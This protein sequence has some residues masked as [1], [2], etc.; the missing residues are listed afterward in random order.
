MVTAFEDVAVLYRRFAA[1]EVRGISPLYDEICTGI[2]EDADVLELLAALPQPKWQPNLLLGAWKFVHGV[3]SGYP[4]FRERLLDDPEAV[5]SVM[6]T[7]A[8]QTNEAARC[9]T[10]L[11]VLASIDGPIALFEVGV[12]AGLCLFPDRYHYRYLTDDG[13]YEVG[14]PS[15]VDLTCEVTGPMPI[16]TRL[17]EIVWRGGIDLNP[18]DIRD[19]ETVRWLR[20]LI[21]PEQPGRLERLDAAIAIARTERTQVVAGNADEQFEAALAAVPRAATLVVLNTA[22]AMYF[23][24]EQR[25]RFAERADRAGVWIAQEQ[26]G[27]LPNVAAALPV[28]APRGKFVLSQ[29]GVPLAFTAPHGGDIEWI[30]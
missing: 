12:S 10:T 25:E 7:H 16:P 9:A 6:R 13:T 20:A 3:A 30:A 4:E 22:T 1:D 19:D 24:P 29:N 2:A 26:A 18:L 23:T 14:E 8:T 11:P 5:R 21:W 27:V 17:P 28:R 15:G